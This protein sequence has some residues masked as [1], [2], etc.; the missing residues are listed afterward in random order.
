MY[1][2]TIGVIALAALTLAVVGTTITVEHVF[3]ALGPAHRVRPPIVVLINFDDSGA[4]LIG[5]NN[6]KITLHTNPST[7]LDSYII[8]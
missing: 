4:P 2:K 6:Y 7:T 1:G 8:R 3:A 5:T